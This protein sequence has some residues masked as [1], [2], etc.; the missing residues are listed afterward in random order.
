MSDTVYRPATDLSELVFGRLERLTVCSTEATQITQA[1]TV[2]ELEKE[3]VDPT[4]LTQAVDRLIFGS[5]KPQASN[6]PVPSH[7]LLLSC[8]SGFRMRAVTA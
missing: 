7:A 2:D 5:M 8:V 3:V 1:E 4:R 6:K